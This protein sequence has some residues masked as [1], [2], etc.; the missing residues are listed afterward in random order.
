[1][2]EASCYHQEPHIAS[3]VFHNQFGIAAKT[4]NTEEGVSSGSP[5]IN[6]CNALSA[7]SRRIKDRRSDDE[8]AHQ[9]A[10][11]LSHARINDAQ[12]GSEAE[13]ACDHSYQL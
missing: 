11:V 5:Y 3:V 6:I 2:K 12:D 8:I 9:R 7:G 4:F 13:V 1:M 10:T